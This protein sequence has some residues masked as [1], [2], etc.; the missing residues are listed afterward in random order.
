MLHF[1]NLN[2]VIPIYV[3]FFFEKF[4]ISIFFHAICFMFQL[5]NFSSK[6]VHIISSLFSC[7]FVLWCFFPN[8]SVCYFYVVSNFNLWSCFLVFCIWCSCYFM[9]F[10]FR[11][12]CHVTTI[13]VICFFFKILH[14]ISLFIMLFNFMFLYLNFSVLFPYYF[15]IMNK[16]YC[17]LK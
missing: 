13:Y 6:I 12:F 4:V 3:S 15:D 11:L 1:P 16:L 5:G 17:N 10:R 2:W 14:I 9:L 7:Y 8:L